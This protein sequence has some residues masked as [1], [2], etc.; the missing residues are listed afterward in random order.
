[1]DPSQQAISDPVLALVGFFCVVVLLLFLA[2]RWKWHVLLALMVPLL[3][4]G[5]MPGVRRSVFIQAFQEGFGNTLG[6]SEWSSFWAR[7]SPS[8]SSTPGPSRSSHGPW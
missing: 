2:A 7:S 8:S 6:R 5:L 1:M 4:L 3:L